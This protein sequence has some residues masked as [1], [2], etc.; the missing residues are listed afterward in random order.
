VSVVCAVLGVGIRHGGDAPPAPIGF[1]SRR[2]R[3][4]P[5]VSFERVFAAQHSSTDRWNVERPGD[6]DPSH[7]LVQNV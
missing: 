6:R 1:Q 2:I 5:A 7:T 3:V 4:A